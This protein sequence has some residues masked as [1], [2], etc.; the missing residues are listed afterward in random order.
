MPLRDHFHPPLSD[1]RD[2]A[3]F[4]ARWSNAIAD[5][6]NELL[7]E[8]Y[9]ADPLTHAGSSVEIDVATFDD[10]HN[11]REHANGRPFLPSGEGQGGIAL[12]EVPKLYTPPVA[13]FSAATAIADDF[14]VRIFRDSGGAKLVAAIELV[15]PSNKDRPESRLA[16]ATKCASY[17]HNSI[18]V[19][20]VDIVTERL[21][22]LHD[23]IVPLFTSDD[24]PQM[25]S[26]SLYSVA[27]RPL[28][29]GGEAK[30]EWWPRSFELGDCLPTL[31][32]WLNAVLAVPVDLEA[33]YTLALRRARIE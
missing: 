27:Y 15:S 5:S 6:L 7:P 14:E 8:R 11:S 32:L 1:Q 20:V 13:E 10:P 16:F 22:N 25:G 21:A 26:G 3:S 30:I 24:I 9:F 31:P 28:V 18:A 29:Q 17:L 19:I 23:E 4:H 33:S 2:W 12:A